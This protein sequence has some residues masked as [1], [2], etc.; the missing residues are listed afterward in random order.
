MGNNIYNKA[1]TYSLLS[2]ISNSGLLS[3]GPLD[4]F[5]PIVKKA[6]HYL[7]SEKGEYKSSKIDEIRNRIKAEY[8]IEIPKVVLLKIL[9]QVALDV[10]QEK[11]YF[12]VFDDGSFWIK[13]FIFED[14]DDQIEEAKTNIKNLQEL[15][16][17]FC[18]IQNI[19]NEENNCVIRFIERHKISMSKYLSNKN[20]T[21]DNTDFLLAA[22]F[23]NYF[24]ENGSVFYEQIKRIYLGSVLSMRL[25]YEPNIKDNNIQLTLLLDTNFIISLIDLNTKESTHTC[26]T[27]LQICEKLNTSFFVLPETIEEIKNLLYYKGETLDSVMISKYVNEEDIYRACE[28]RNLT[29]VDL[30]RIADNIEEMLSK[31]KINIVGNTEKLRNKARFSD[32]YKKLKIVRN[33]DLA[34][35]H[36]AMA[37]IYVREKRGKKIKEFEKANC[38]FVNNSFSQEST[39]NDMSLQNNNYQPESIKA[40]DLLNILWLSSPSINKS[41][42]T[43]EISDIG[44]TSLIAFTFNESLPS[45]RIIRE[46]DANIERY[47][48]ENITEKDVHYL[49]IRV[50]N[51]QL[52]SIQVEELN[53]LAKQNSTEFN[54]RLREEV[55]KQEE[56]EKQKSERFEQVILAFGRKM[57]DID[58]RTIELD[59]LKEETKKQA[60]IKINNALEEKTK[61]EQENI[62]L[63]AERRKEKDENKLLK[64]T[65]SKIDELKPQKES[66]EEERE[67]SVSMVK[68]W[69]IIA[70]ESICLCVSLA[71]ATYY[72]LI[73]TGDVTIKSMF[74]DN[75]LWL[76]LVSTSFLAVITRICSSYLSSPKITYKKLK[77][78]QY[79]HWDESHPEYQRISDNLMDLENT[80][81]N[82]LNRTDVTES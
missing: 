33:T 41:I 52:N 16:R 82:I 57:Q 67:K 38:W 42:N 70:L 62:K 11:E 81:N 47:A 15:F 40:D 65:I 31:K 72:L 22:N 20:T 76:I 1:V 27:L 28:R 35:L 19:D 78:D 46:L 10:N 54:Q 5:I 74:N 25:D 79:A 36:D 7:H 45:S 17:E 12:Q 37:L 14:F 26:N 50:T 8:G 32:E 4:I 18:K 3:R 23:I 80:K 43:Q 71:G 2:H 53:K 68:Y 61:I 55:S 60:S 56:I 29:K 77:S 69:L 39:E 64:D 30:D 66:L 34:A 24:K 63:V 13:G 44:L 49:S 48:K 9:K 59:K 58:N 21:T 73:Y 75:P 51:K 6:L